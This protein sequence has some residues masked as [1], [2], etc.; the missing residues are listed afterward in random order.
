MFKVEEIPDKGTVYVRVHKNNIKKD[1]TAAPGAFH[2][3]PSDG[4]G[5]SSNWSKYS[6]PA[7]C[8]QGAR[9]SED[10]Y[11]VVEFGVG[12][13]RS[14]S[15]QLPQEV[16]HTPVPHNQSH[17]TIFGGKSERVRVELSRLASWIIVYPQN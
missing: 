6:S 5:L 8:L 14:I 10:N 1:G 4:T 15:V 13:I 3:T 7:C 16:Q 2:N 12:N 9:Q 17:S 11:G